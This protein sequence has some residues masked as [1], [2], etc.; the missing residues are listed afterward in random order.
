MNLPVLTFDPTRRT[1]AALIADAHRLGYIAADDRVLDV[2]YGRGRF[3]S[4]WR[5]T[6]LVG[7]DIDPLFAPHG[8]ADFTALPYA[9]H[10]W[11]VVVFD[12]P[13]KLNGTSAHPSDTAYGV[14]GPYV[15]AGDRLGALAAGCR[16]AARVARRVVLVKCQDQVVS[17]RKVW[18]T[19]IATNAVTA[20]PEWRKADRLELFGSRPQPAGRRQVHSRTT[21]ST[22]LVFGRR[23]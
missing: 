5:P 2:T 1:N 18:Q 7:H 3:W 19:D 23:A 14:G 16:E 8:P 6:L 17:G 15:R 9:D 20:D 22:L 4:E 12:P 13:Y 21:T 11:D 10:S